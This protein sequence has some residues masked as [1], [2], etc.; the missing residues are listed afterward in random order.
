MSEKKVVESNAIEG[1]RDG[2]DVVSTTRHR[3]KD[4]ITQEE[5]ERDRTKTAETETEKKQ[6]SS[7]SRKIKEWKQIASPHRF[8]L[9][10]CRHGRERAVEEGMGYC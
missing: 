4:T 7:G 6:K 2:N 3:E 10:D 5:S 8:S 9:R 1:G